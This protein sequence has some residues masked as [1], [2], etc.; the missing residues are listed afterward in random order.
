M[1]IDNFSYQ[2]KLELM[3]WFEGITTGINPNFKKIIK[4]LLELMTWFEGITTNK[5][6]HQ[7]YYKCLRLEL[8][9][10]FEGIT[11]LGQTW[12]PALAG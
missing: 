7:V 6:R 4:K 5:K 1:L 8:M 3:T 12:F 2:N 9:T 11:T 10:W